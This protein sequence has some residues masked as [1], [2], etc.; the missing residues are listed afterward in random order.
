M[1]EAFH[2][3]RTPNEGINQRNLKIWQTKYAMAV[4]KVLGVGVDFRPCSAV[5]AISSTGVRSPWGSSCHLDFTTY[6]IILDK[7]LCISMICNEVKATGG[8]KIGYYILFW[9]Y[10]S[11]VDMNEAFVE[12]RRSLLKKFLTEGFAL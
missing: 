10:K 8:T 1:V 6:Q 11:E 4:P 9:K 3:L 7:N 5:K 12:F 2:G